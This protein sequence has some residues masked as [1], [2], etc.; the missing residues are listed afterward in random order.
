M[1]NVSQTW[2]LGYLKKEVYIISMFCYENLD[3]I[4]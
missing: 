4:V 3:I 2:Y 1:I